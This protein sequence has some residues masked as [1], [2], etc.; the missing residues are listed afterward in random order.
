M[1]NIGGGELLL[2]AAVA[3]LILGPQR[4]PEM[5][6]S[7][8][9]ALREIRRHTDSVRGVVESEFYKMD[10]QLNREIIPKKLLEEAP[11]QIEGSVAKGQA[12]IDEKPLDS[13]KP[14][15]QAER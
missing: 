5:A 13:P 9:R 10:E 8:G 4:L 7:L 6:R 14:S 15:A 12:V 1:F 3:L 2:I 11:T